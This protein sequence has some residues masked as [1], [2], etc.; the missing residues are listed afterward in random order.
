LIDYRNTY[1]GGS[2]DVVVDVSSLGTTLVDAWKKII[3]HLSFQY[4]EDALIWKIAKVSK[5]FSLAKSYV[6]DTETT[7]GSLTALTTGTP[8]LMTIEVPTFSGVDSVDVAL[9][10]GT[11]FNPT[12]LSNA[13]AIGV[14]ITGDGTTF[15]IDN[16]RECKIY[17]S[18]PTSATLSYVIDYPT[19]NE[20]IAV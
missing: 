13:A 14:T 16:D 1:I 17:F 5:T 6:R 12:D 18:K 11:A 8:L 15:T 19:Y 4:E 20:V 2:A 10:Y 3:D 7:D 9:W